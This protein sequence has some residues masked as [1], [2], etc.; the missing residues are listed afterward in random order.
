M[1]SVPNP[2]SY[3]LGTDF[4]QRIRNNTPRRVQDNIFQW[5]VRLNQF[6]ADTE[7]GADL[8]Q[9]RAQYGYEYV[10]LQ[11][12]F[13]MDLY[14]FF[15][16]LVKVGLQYGTQYFRVPSNEVTSSCDIKFVR[17]QRKF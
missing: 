9:I 10:E 14:P 3:F 17:S 11:L 12:D 5:S 15:P 4:S 16:P 6:G 1:D 8:A 2:D 7:L 13:S